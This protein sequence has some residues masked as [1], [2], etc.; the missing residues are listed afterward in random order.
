MVGFVAHRGLTAV[1]LGWDAAQGLSV[2]FGLA[3]LTGPR[4]LRRRP[5]VGVSLANRSPR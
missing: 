5:L 3:I 2:L 1:A 4:L